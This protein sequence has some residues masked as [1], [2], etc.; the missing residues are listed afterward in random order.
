MFFSSGKDNEVGTKKAADVVDDCIESE[1]IKTQGK[2]YKD[3]RG[4]DRASYHSGEASERLE[5]HQSRRRQMIKH[6]IHI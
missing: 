4:H 2:L 3:P 1:G 5:E 6:I